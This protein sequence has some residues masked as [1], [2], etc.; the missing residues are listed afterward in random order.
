MIRYKNK[1]KETYIK[2]KDLDF[3]SQI[4]SLKDKNDKEFQCLMILILLK[5]QKMKYFNI[6]QDLDI[7]LLEF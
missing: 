2:I 1:I 6:E 3:K 4:E 7:L 5:I